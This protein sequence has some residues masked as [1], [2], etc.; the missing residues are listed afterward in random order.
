[1]T[2]IERLKELYV[3]TRIYRNFY[4][5]VEPKYGAVRQFCLDCSLLSLVEI[6]LMENSCF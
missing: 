1:M 5:G 4:K 3:E 2:P 6:E